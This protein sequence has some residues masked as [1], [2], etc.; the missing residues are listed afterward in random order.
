MFE[1]WLKFSDKGAV[2]T[3]SDLFSSPLWYNSK[4][5]CHDMY[6]PIWFEKGIKTI[7]DIINPNSFITINPLH[8][9]RVKHNVK[10]YFKKYKFDD[11]YIVQRPFVP[12][13]IV[14]IWKNKKGVSAFYKTLTKH[15]ENEHKIKLKWEN[16]M[17]VTIDKSVWS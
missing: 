6:I 12:F 15:N 11:V 9:L 17:Q 7:S 13:H 1:A 5:S 16:E 8:Y 10:Q 3:N 4:M 2:K 14:P